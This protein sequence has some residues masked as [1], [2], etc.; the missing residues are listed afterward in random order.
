MKKKVLALILI[1]II[2]ISATLSFAYEDD[3]PK[4]FSPYG[5]PSNFLEY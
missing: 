4:I 1:C 3:V 5:I 2:M